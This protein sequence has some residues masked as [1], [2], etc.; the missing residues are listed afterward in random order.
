MIARQKPVVLLLHG[1]PSD[2]ADLSRVARALSSDYRAVV[3]DLPGS[4]RSDAFFPDYG[5]GAQAQAALFLLRHLGAKSAFVFA[6]SL[7]AGAALEMARL[8]PERLEAIVSYG[9]VG[10]QKGEGSGS[11]TVE[12]FKYR[13]GFVPLVLLP[14]LLPHFGLFGSFRVRNT[15][16]RNFMDTDMRPLAGIL[17]TSKVPILLLHGA[18]DPLVPLWAA[19]EHARL[20][21]NGSLHV[22]NESHFLIF[23]EPGSRRIASIARNYF[24]SVRAAK[25]VGNPPPRSV[26]RESGIAGAPKPPVDLGLS[27]G[28]SGWARLTAIVLG[29]FVSEDLTCIATGLLVRQGTVDLFT[30]LIGCYLGIFLGDLGLFFLGRLL[31]LGILKLPALRRTFTG[32]VVARLERRFEREGMRLLFLSRFVPGMRLPVYVGAGLLGGAAFR[33]AAVA[34]V[35]GMIWTP[36]LVMVAAIFGPAATKPL[37][38][39]FGENILT[40]LVAAVLLFLVL[41]LPLLLLTRDGRRQIRKTAG[42]VMRSEFW[43]PFIFYAPLVPL[44]AA[45]A[46]R[47]RGFQTLCAANPGIPEG[48]FIGESKLQILDLIPSEA[49]LP[50]FG[51]FPGAFPQRAAFYRAEVE[52]RGMIYPLI[53]KPDVAQRG[54][55]L[56]LCRSEEAAL[57]YVKEFEATLVVQTYHPGPFEAGV[58]YVRFPGQ[59]RGRIFSITDKIFPVITGDGRS[60]IEELIW[61]HPRFFLQADTFLK[62]FAGRSDEV[63]PAAEKLRLAIAG[64]HI[65]GTLFRDGGHLL[66]PQLEEAIDSVAV[67]TPGFFFGRFDMRYASADDFRSGTELAILELNGATAESTNI[68]DPQRSLWFTYRTLFQQW[69]LLFQIGHANRRL[70]AQVPKLTHLL[71]M[72][73]RYRREQK[74]LPVSD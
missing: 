6:H 41:R 21:R 13:I 51:V 70:G 63:L 40:L 19:E 12:H 36:L 60:T 67:R 14:E 42:R 27:P 44:V 29:T 9:G 28:A 15:L 11:Y 30:G 1:S 18:H 58:F 64:N 61:R 56:R 7:G 48:G 72:L 46:L 62:R 37:A 20:A 45:L 55:G 3:P 34:L 35:A 66:T 39:L 24:E 71:G 57:A 43:P 49:V 16:V 68:F 17:R 69:I 10:S 26:Y 32:P 4:G 52:K 54:I 2:A 5:I 73:W 38:A 22:L 33:M 31:R 65:Q 53:L 74:A 47:F 23:S 50:Y 8:K 59:Q 25:A